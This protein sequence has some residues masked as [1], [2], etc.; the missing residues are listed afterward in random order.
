MYQLKSD[1]S[2][3]LNST[4]RNKIVDFNAKHFDAQRVPLGYKFV[5][6]NNELM[7]CISGCVFGNWLIINWLW[8]SE[9]ARNEG[10]A[11]QLLTELEQAAILLGA[12]KAQLDTLDFQAKP[13]YEKRGYSV[14]YQLDNYPL[15]GTRY[16]MEKPL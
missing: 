4:L 1:N 10:L 12:K 7:A 14:K 11:G 2:D 5:D 6:N 9:I 8:C 3:A 13:F 15:C 16:F